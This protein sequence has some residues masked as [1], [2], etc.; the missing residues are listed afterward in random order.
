MRAYRIIAGFLFAASGALSAPG[1]EL[2]AVSA[3]QLVREVVFNELNDHAR[4]GYW[5]Y[6]VERRTQSGTRLEEQVETPEGP[7]TRLAGNDGRPLGEPAQRQEQARL[8]RLLSSP[9]ERA[10]H[11]EEYNEDEKRIARIVVLLPDAFLYDYDGMDDGCY[12]LRFHPNP[13]YPARSI[14]ARIFH[15]MSGT[16][17]VN[18]QSKR[19]ARL[20]GR[21]GEN[22]DFGFGILGRLYKGGWFKLMRTQVS[23]TDWKTAQLEVHVSIRALLV[24]TFA[25][26]TSE[27]RGGF[28]PVPV[29]LTLAQAMRLLAPPGPQAPATASAP[30]SA[31][32]LAVR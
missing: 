27:R 15:A 19:L 26:E 10:R 16:L 7:L 9:A 12:R 20:D 4:H 31:A 11:L 18:A 25:R 2:P 28:E 17:W 5:R 1:Q 14:E 32:A 23:P 6:W 30:I 29:D 21:V 24:K 3:G 13:S 22:V 8:E